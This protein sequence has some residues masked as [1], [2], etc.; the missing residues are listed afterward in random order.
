MFVD[1]RAK[2][3][4][5]LGGNTIYIKAK[6]DYGTTAA[7]QDEIKATG[8]GNADMVIEKLGSYRMALLTHNI[9]GWE[10][11]DFMDETGRLIPCNRENIRRLDPSEPLVEMVA[12][13]IGKRNRKAESPDPN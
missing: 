13:E 8:A 12:D 11:P 1:T 10:G 9:V 2:V 5:S 6:M 4:V 7:V 3:P